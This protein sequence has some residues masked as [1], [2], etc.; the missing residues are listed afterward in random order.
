LGAAAAGFG[1]LDL[2]AAAR[3]GAARFVF[4]A[5]ALRAGFFAFTDLPRRAAPARRRAAVLAPVLR[6][7]VARFLPAFLVL[8]VFLDFRAALTI[9]SSCFCSSDCTWRGEGPQKSPPPIPNSRPVMTVNA[10]RP[11]H[12]FCFRERC[13]AF[14]CGP[15]V[16]QSTS[17]TVWT[18]GMSVTNSS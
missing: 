2:R 10:G 13:N 9:T 17:S 8:V 12:P 1:A 18:I 11:S 14:G 7:V 16:A 6:L 4:L 15:P 5:A 3:L